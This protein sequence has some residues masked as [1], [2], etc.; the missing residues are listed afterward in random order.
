MS[1]KCSGYFLFWK[2]DCV[3]EVK[4]IFNK[5]FYNYVFI[6][7][8]ILLYLVFCTIFLNMTSLML[9]S[10]SIKPHSLDFISNLY[11]LLIS[12][13]SETNSSEWLRNLC[14]RWSEPDLGLP[15]VFGTARALAQDLLMTLLVD[16]T[17]TNYI[18]TIIKN[19]CYFS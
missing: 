11:S 13:S 16:S 3:S 14:Y 10:L 8:L 18:I 1:I 6:N 2:A 15:A 4:Q 12:R 19:L 7:F 5:S 9:K 17:V